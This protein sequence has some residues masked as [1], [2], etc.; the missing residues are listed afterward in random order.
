MSLNVPLLGKTVKLISLE[1][2]S[3]LSALPQLARGLLNNGLAEL[4]DA[5]CDGT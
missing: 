5:G 3:P 4:Y 2:G 1:P